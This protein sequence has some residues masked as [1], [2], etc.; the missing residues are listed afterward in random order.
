MQNSLNS[1]VAKPKILIVDD[2]PDNLQVLL[3]ILKADYAIVAATTG[4]KA[5][6]MAMRQPVPDLIVLDVVMPEIDGYEVCKQLQANSTTKDIP[7]ILVTGLGD[8]SNEADGFACGAVDY[9]TKPL[10]PTVIKARIKNHLALRRLNK[11]LQTQNAD[12]LRANR[13]KDEFLAKMSYELRTPLHI[14][15]GINEMLQENLL[16]ELK[17]EQ[18]K[19][20][21][22][23]DHSA[24]HLLE[25]LNDVVELAQ[26]NSG[27]T[28]LDLA[29]TEIVSV[30]DYS[31]AFIRPQTYH[32]KI[33]LSTQFAEDL[34]QI[35]VDERLIRQALTNLLN[36][37]VEYTPEG[38]KIAIKVRKVTEERPPSTV[39]EWLRISVTD[40]GTGL[41]EEDVR[42]LSQTF[43]RGDSAFDREHT[44]F[45]FGLALVKS[46]L[47]LHGGHLTISSQIG[48]GS[49]F[50]IELPYVTSASLPMTAARLQVVR[51]EGVDVRL[52]QAPRI[53]VVEDNE[54]EQESITTYLKAKGYCV[55]CANNGNM[56]IDQVQTHRP[57]LILMDI[58][59]PVMDGLEAIR[60]IRL[61]EDSAQMPIIALTG[62][63]MQG[64][65]DRCL[66]AGATD[67][68]SKPVRL[69]EL[70]TK[71]QRLLGDSAIQAS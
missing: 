43:T 45:G 56:A 55:I 35:M 3:Q 53:L 22:S 46:V 66:A 44:G 67:Y 6:Q 54:V 10:D 60:A 12:L 48:G 25:L 42:R 26:I 9:I 63:A 4:S 51:S 1:I 50:A 15:L 5:L 32:K 33:R 57:N 24:L 40:T 65:R 49:C 7:V 37:A 17:V 36:N 21:A 27:Q 28:G 13:L 71:I 31:L 23:I 62:L 70:H 41:P 59:M 64:D 61:R 39:A 58:Q 38:G 19:A 68:V 29:P 52:D 18:S 34:P 14:I 69:K 20:I 47:D 30:C 11:D 2:C 8:A 16:G